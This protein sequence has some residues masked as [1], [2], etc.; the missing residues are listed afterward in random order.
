[1][2][3]APRRTCLNDWTEDL[4]VQLLEILRRMEEDE[5]EIRRVEGRCREIVE[6]MRGDGGER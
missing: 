3:R 6:E 5:L 4:S 2:Q 1:M